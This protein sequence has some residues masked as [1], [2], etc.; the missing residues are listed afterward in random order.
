MASVLPQIIPQRL[1]W[2][3]V[4]LWSVV[5]GGCGFKPAGS[6]S[7]PFSRLYVTAPAYTS[8]GAEFKRYV[9]SGS[10][11]ELVD[12][13]EQAQA[14]LEIF[15]EVQTKQI[16]SLTSSGRVAEY[17]LLYTVAFR[18][19][20]N[21]NRDWIPRS[22]IS[23]RRSLTYD[24]SAALAKEIEEQRLYEGMKVDAIQQL[25]RRLEAARAPA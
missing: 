7:M 22:E 21:E 17:L 5:A 6:A 8:F 13:P 24:D 10:Q 19:R 3:T 12:K 1:L 25:M 11:V 16:L 23:L 15:E 14:V 9:Q 2:L 4:L 18:L 20:D